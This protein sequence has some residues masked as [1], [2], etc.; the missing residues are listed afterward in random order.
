M[1]RS[2]PLRALWPRCA[3]ISFRSLDALI[4][5]V[6]FRPLDAG[7]PVLAVHARR[8][9]FSCLSFVAFIALHSGSDPIVGGGIRF[10]VYGYVLNRLIGDPAIEDPI[11]GFISLPRI[12]LAFIGGADLADL[13]D[14]AHAI[15]TSNI[16]VSGLRL[17]MELSTGPPLYSNC[18]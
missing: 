16:P 14:V 17:N 2:G 7:S 8:S 9:P 1:F 11:Q 3:C 4:S 13:H 5:L 12:P 18:K 6:A 15:M 10:P